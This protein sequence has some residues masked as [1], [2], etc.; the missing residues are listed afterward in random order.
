[1]ITIKDPREL[2]SMRS[3]GRIVAEVLNE[4]AALV[5]PGVTTAALDRFAEDYLIKKGA[6]PAFKGYN[7][8]PASICASVNEEVVHGIPGSRRLYDGDIIS[9]DVGAFLE[10][11]CG[12]AAI[13]VAVGDVSK[14]AQKLIKVTEEALYEGIKQ[15]VAGARLGMVSHAIQEHAE[16]HKLS[17]VRQ[18]VGH[19]I[20]KQMH[21]DPPVPNYGRQDRGPVLEPGMTIAI[22][23]M[24]N[25]GV[26]EVIVKPDNWTVITRDGKYS[27]HFE[28]TIAITEQGPE[29]LTRM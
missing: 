9:I 23:P 29:I 13:T 2:K 25:L 16:Q 19:G 1:M 18:Y 11:Y 8:F 12:D 7:G 28:H 4:L 17:V 6:I 5:K 14:E 21:E 24:I 10:G 15:A 27:A 22:E 20:G 26:W 3:A